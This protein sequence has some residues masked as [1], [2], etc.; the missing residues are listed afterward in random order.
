MEIYLFRHP[1]LDKYKNI[2][3]Q[4]PLTLMER[5]RNLISPRDYLSFKRCARGTAVQNYIFRKGTELF[6]ERTELFR[7]GTEIFRK[8]TELFR[9][10]TK[11]SGKIP[12]YSG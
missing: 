5:C 1:H 6:R 9:V 12:N 2:K 11:I 8:D 10:G 4:S 3:G 7:A